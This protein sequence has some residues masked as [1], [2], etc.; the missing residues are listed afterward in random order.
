MS[1]NPG[2]IV[3]AYEQCP[4]DQL[5]TEP[6]HTSRGTAQNQVRTSKEM[7]NLTNIVSALQK[8]IKL[9]KRASGLR[10]A[11]EVAAKHEGW[12]AGYGDVTGPKGTPDGI[13][14]VYVTDKNGNLKIIN[15]YQLKRSDHPHREMW[16][17]HVPFITKINKNGEEYTRRAPIKKYVRDVEFPL[18]GDNGID[19]TYELAPPNQLGANLRKKMEDSWAGVRRTF[20][21]VLLGYVWDNWKRSSNLYPHMTT[22]MKLELFRIWSNYQWQFFLK[23]CGITHQSQINAGRNNPEL[24]ETLKENVHHKSVDNEYLDRIMNELDSVAM[25]PA[26]AAWVQ[27][28]IIDDIPHTTPPKI[29]QMKPLKLLGLRARVEARQ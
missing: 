20:I 21:K 19:G 17:D 16:A 5:Y 23:E 15:G 1:R 11:Q 27:Y 24:I 14:E 10:G 4:D 7:A 6:Y 29:K 22:E 12:M 28:K 3:G 26:H 2:D 18:F 9:I 25:D 8:D 13:A